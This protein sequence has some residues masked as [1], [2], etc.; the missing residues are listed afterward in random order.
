[1]HR[2]KKYQ[3]KESDTATPEI[4]A[5]DCGDER[6][7]REVSSWI[8]SP[9]G[10]NSVV[11]DMRQFGIAVWL[12]RA[13]GELVGFASLGENTWSFPPPKGPKRRICYIPFIG[14]QKKF[15]GEPKDSDDK[16]SSQILDDVI[17]CAVAQMHV[18]PAIGL[19]VDRDNV[20]A[21][22]FYEK[23]GFTNAKSPRTDKTT[24]VVYERMFMIISNLREAPA[25]DQPA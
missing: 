14:I 16:Y 15:W 1:M 13:D 20:R 18:Y 11:E 5:F 25:P 8:K 23:R 21:I 4:Q 22:R 17:E 9:S 24:G 7:E 19:S 12:Y 2:L 3:F 6:W 10:Q